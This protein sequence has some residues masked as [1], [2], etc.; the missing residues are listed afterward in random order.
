MEETK[1][2]TKEAPEHVQTPIIQLKEL[3]SSFTPCD[4]R[5]FAT[6]CAQLHHLVKQRRAQPRDGIPP[7]SSIPA[8]IGNKC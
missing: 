3:K 6:R 4:M 1:I 8:R 2:M 7:F 5:Q